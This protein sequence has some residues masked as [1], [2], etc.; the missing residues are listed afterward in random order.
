MIRTGEYFPVSS[1][2][3]RPGRRRARARSHAGR[4]GGRVAMMEND[5]DPSSEHDQQH[6]SPNHYGDESLWHRLLGA[7]VGSNNE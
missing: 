1:E 4:S 6:H 3:P 5:S 2:S 7:E